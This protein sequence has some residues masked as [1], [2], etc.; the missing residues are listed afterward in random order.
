MENDE[1]D[2]E[3]ITKEVLLC[4]TMLKKTLTTNGMS[5]GVYNNKLIFFKTS[6]YLETNDILKCQHFAVTIDDLV[7]EGN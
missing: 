7:K 1:K 5:I 2:F 6:E 3:G 4:L